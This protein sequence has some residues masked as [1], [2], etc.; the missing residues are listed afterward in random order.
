MGGAKATPCAGKGKCALG[1]HVDHPPN[2]A[3]DAAEFALG[4]GDCR[5]A[6]DANF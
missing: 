5:G 4:C 3:D 2:S 6:G 1:P